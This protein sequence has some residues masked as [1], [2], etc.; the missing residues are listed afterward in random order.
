MTGRSRPPTTTGSGNSGAPPSQS[1]ARRGKQP[2]VSTAPSLTEMPRKPTLWPWHWASEHGAIAHAQGCALCDA[3]ITHLAVERKLGVKS[4]ERALAARNADISAKSRDEG[5]SAGQVEGLHDAHLAMTFDAEQ[6]IATLQ[7]MVRALENNNQKLEEKLNTFRLAHGIDYEDE[8]GVYDAMSDDDEV[9]RP[10]SKETTA[11]SLRLYFSTRSE[12]W[13]EH[14]RDVERIARLSQSA[15]ATVSTDQEGDVVMLPPDL[16]SQDPSGP[17]LPPQAE[18]DRSERHP[19]HQPLAARSGAN[20]HRSPSARPLHRDEHPDSRSPPRVVPTRRGRSPS[21][22]YTMPEPH[23]RDRARS[24]HGR[25][26]RSYS[27]DRRGRYSREPSPD[28]SRPRSRSPSRGSDLPAYS[29]PR[30]N[31]SAFA[32]FYGPGYGHFAPPMGLA[33]GG[34]G[35]PVPMYHGGPAP[36]Y[37]EHS[38]P[39]P[40]YYPDHGQYQHQAPSNVSAPGRHYPAR[41]PPPTV[42]TTAPSPTGTLPPVR[43]TQR[44][45]P[46]LPTNKE[47]LQAVIMAAEHDSSA[48]LQAV[49]KLR[50]WSSKLHEPGYK[51]NDVERELALL[52]RIPQW[53]REKYSPRHLERSQPDPSGAIRAEPRP[54]DSVEQWRSYLGGTGKSGLLPRHVR[55]DPVTKEPDALTVRGFV[56]ANRFASIDLSAVASNECKSTRNGLFRALARLFS[57]SVFYNSELNRLGIFAAPDL[58]V[59]PFPGPFPPNPDDIVRHSANC[60][61]SLGLT[62]TG[63]GLTAWAAHHLESTSGHGEVAPAPPAPN[64]GLGAATPG[65]ETTATTTQA[66]PIGGATAVPPGDVEMQESAPRPDEASH[67]GGA[68]P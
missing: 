47:E 58:R 14:R 6:E 44:N 57:S 20:R 17:Q 30:A 65:G 66:V 28:R 2:D 29:D 37:Y 22:A 53:Y 38:G 61:I 54:Q 50:Y 43:Y 25:V 32:P 26:G 63:P 45:A 52:F 42:Q 64:D 21:P 55:R 19:V 59:T 68:A 35:G 48:G 7:A 12:R 3:Y 34:R 18:P 67:A 10:V 51:L 31:P 46:E 16:D 27:V 11:K 24:P 8:E 33:Q 39:A 62:S 49:G 1:R 5:Y 15:L 4:L 23:R 56:W 36:T 41:R 13:K 40:M 60:G 9:V